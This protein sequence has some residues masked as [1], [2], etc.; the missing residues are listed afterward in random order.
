MNQTMHPSHREIQHYQRIGKIAMILGGIWLG[1]L[2][3]LLILTI[4][5]FAG[6][7]STDGLSP[8]FFTLLVSLGLSIP[9]LLYFLAGRAAL[10]GKKWSRYALMVMGIFLLP[11]FPLGTAVGVYTL[12]FYF[13]D[14]A[15]G[16]FKN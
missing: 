11:G 9:S 5:N 3:L 13:P 4:V 8:I 2:A 15:E 12:I 16:Y 6:T 10:K 7:A 1:I 14:K